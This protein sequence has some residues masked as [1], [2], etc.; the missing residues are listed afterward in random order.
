VTNPRKAVCFLALLLMACAPSVLAQGTYTQID[1]P[2]SES[3]TVCQGINDADDIVGSYGPT[4]N[5][6][7]WNGFLLSGGVYTTIDY[8]SDSY[9]YLMGINNNGK[10]AGHDFDGAIGFTYDMQSQTFTSISYP[11]S[12]FTTPTSI[13]NSGAV[14]GYFLSNSRTVHGFEL[15]GTTYTEILQPGQTTV[16]ISGIRESNLFDGNVV[17]DSSSHINFSYK[18]GKYRKLTIPGTQVA[19]VLGISED[20][21]ALVGTYRPTAGITAGFLY[22]NN[23]LQTLQFPGSRFTVAT[24]VNDD[25][26]VV[27]YFASAN[28]SHG[29]TWTP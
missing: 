23:I 27:G 18:N 21:S 19:T 13:N 11:G 12:Q 2:G 10:I 3:S 4:A 26:V 1:V 16:T 15:N 28:H 29:F 22:R 7:A 8:P 24:G 20:G 6:I 17:A 14:A 5:G 9:T 25:G